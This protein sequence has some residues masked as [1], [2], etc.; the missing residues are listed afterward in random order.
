ML[1]QEFFVSAI[2][3]VFAVFLLVLAYKI[4]HSNCHTFIKSKIFQLELSDNV[5]ERNFHEENLESETY[6]DTT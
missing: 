6:Y 5:P 2:E 1:T 3:N 4:Y